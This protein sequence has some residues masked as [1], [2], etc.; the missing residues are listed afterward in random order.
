M[1]E[2]RCGSCSLCCKLAGV[3]EELDKPPNKWCQHCLIGIGCKIHEIRPQGC[4][5]F[6][7][8]F[9][10]NPQMPEELRPSNCHVVF[11]VFKPNIILALVDPNRRDAWKKKSVQRIIRSLA[12]TGK[13]VII[14]DNQHAP[15][16][17]LPETRKPEDVMKE[18]YDELQRR[19]SGGDRGYGDSR[20][21][22][23]VAVFVR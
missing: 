4:R 11:E 9:Y 19:F 6:E 17:V 3:K 13:S 21:V 22:E 2:S 12:A 10:Q 8:L 15:V 16:F 18:L 14:T 23:D 5:D 20:V 7:C 1:A